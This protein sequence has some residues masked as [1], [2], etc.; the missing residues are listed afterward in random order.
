LWPNF[1]VLSGIRL[2]GLWKTTKNLSRD[3]R[4]LGLDLNTGLCE[5]EVGVLATRPQL[6][7]TV[8]TEAENLTEGSAF[9]PYF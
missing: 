1:K 5:Y 4:S 3:R 6:V 9:C 8:V 7:V 2:E